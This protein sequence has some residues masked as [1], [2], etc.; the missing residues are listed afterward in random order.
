MAPP[1]KDGPLS[2]FEPD[3]ACVMCNKSPAQLFKQCRSY[4]YCSRECQRGDWP[5]HKLLCRKFSTQASRP[6][7]N[8]KRAIFFPEDNEQPQMIWLLC[9]SKRDYENGARYELI[10]PSSFIGEGHKIGY[11][12][13]NPI[14][15]RNLGSCFRSKVGYSVALVFRDRFLLDG[16]R[17]NKSLLKCVGKSPPHSWRGPMVA[18]LVTP[19]EFYEDVNLSDFRHVI[20]Y[21]ATY[22]T[23]ETPESASGPG[24]NSSTTI[25]GVK[26]C[27]YGE[28]KMHGLTRTSLWTYQSPTQRGPPGNKAQSHQF[29]NCLACPSDFGNT[30][31]L[32]PGSTRPDRTRACVLTD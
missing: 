11:I 4:W 19:H 26:I 8:H 7:P 2:D 15:G 5:S 9:E 28:G 17:P 3:D 1:P 30:Q 20:D 10:R 13:R 29:P 16:P 14:R 18:V 23:V 32:K 21:T 12:E 27:C 6:S 24:E 25:R 22:R 31:T